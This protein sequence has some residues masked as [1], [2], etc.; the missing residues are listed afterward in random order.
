MKSEMERLW[1]QGVPMIIEIKGQGFSAQSEDDPPDSLLLEQW[2][3][4]VVP[5]R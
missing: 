1:D 4:Q 3:I 5:K 2:T